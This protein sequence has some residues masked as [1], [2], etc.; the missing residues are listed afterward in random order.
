MNKKTVIVVD[1]FPVV[2]LGL[3]SILEE[4]GDF[5]FK[6]YAINVYAMR[7]ILKYRTP[8]LIIVDSVLP[9]SD[10]SETLKELKQTAPF[11]H[12]LL[13]CSADEEFTSVLGLRCGVKGIISKRASKDEIVK[14]SRTVSCGGTF[15]SGTAAEKLTTYVVKNDIGT[16]VRKRPVFSTREY[17]V[18][19][20]LTGGDSIAKIAKDFAL[21]PKTVATYR[22]R[23]M[24]KIGVRSL[25]GLIRYAL[26]NDLLS[27]S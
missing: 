14:A 12:I 26:Q 19:K 23:L 4:A 7:A 3:K 21:S 24:G 2:A 17:M 8:D 10:L 5:E 22:E 16:A 9:K 27:D 15:L 18:L 1:D 6:G 20:R 13:F 11:S 25:A